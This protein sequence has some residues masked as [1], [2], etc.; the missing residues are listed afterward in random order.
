VAEPSGVNR[1]SSFSQVPIPI[2][3]ALP[4]ESQSAIFQ[5]AA[6][7]CRKVVV[8]TNI[9]ETSLTVDGILYVVDTGYFKENVHD[10]GVDTLKAG[11]FE[12]LEE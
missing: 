12:S 1:F 11:V 7:G 5:S 10:R 6:P 8:A 2:Y 3:A 4:L 9:A